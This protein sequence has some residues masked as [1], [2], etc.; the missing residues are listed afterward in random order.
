[1]IGSVITFLHICN[2]SYCTKQWVL[3]G[4]SYTSIALFLSGIHPNTALS[5]IILPP[6]F[7]FFP[8]SQTEPLYFHV[9]CIYIWI[10]RV[11]EGVISVSLSP[12]VLSFPQL[13]PL[14]PLL[15]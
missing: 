6:I 8:S 13:S 15:C 5:P 11:R 14:V 10:L 3:V 4:H 1:M 7:A 12:C 2:I 9:M